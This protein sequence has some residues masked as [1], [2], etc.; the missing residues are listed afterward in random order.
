MSYH[1]RTNTRDLG[2]SHFHRTFLPPDQYMMDIDYLKF[3][4]SR[5]T[6][7]I[8]AKF[9]LDTPTPNW[10]FRKYDELSR[11]LEV[12]SFSV[13]YEYPDTYK[14]THECP[15]CNCHFNADAELD[16]SKWRF[17]IVPINA[18]DI[19]TIHEMDGNTMKEYLLRLQQAHLRI[20]R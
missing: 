15:G 3:S 16:A 11:L 10:Q 5:N 14:P 20:E 13:H 7:I 19:K 1:E 9:G 6:A 4:P 12:P 8:E 2:F 17:K 18:P